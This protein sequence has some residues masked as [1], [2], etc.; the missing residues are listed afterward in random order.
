MGGLDGGIHAAIEPASGEDTAP[1]SFPAAL[2]KALRTDQ[3]DWSLP[4]HRRGTLGGMDAATCP[5]SV[6]GEGPAAGAQISR[7]AAALCEVVLSVAFTRQPWRRPCCPGN[8]PPLR[9]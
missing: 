3:L 5:A 4:A 1:D 7:P 6:G 2:L 8:R 9:P